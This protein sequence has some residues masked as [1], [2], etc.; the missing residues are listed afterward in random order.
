MNSLNIRAIARARRGRILT[1]LTVALLLSAAIVVGGVGATG[2]SAS[3]RTKACGFLWRYF[4][5]VSARGT[6][7]GTA[8]RIA[9]R[10][11]PVALGLHPRFPRR[12]LGFRCRRISTGNAGGGWRAE[13]RKGHAIVS[14]V[15]T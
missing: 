10:Y 7:C 2:A 9:R 3:T 13:C 5:D 14:M 4:T 1:A 8:L 11:M 15:P 12:E 6:S